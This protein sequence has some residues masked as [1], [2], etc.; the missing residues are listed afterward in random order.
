MFTL[1][2]VTSRSSSKLLKRIRRGIAHRIPAFEHI[3]FSFLTIGVANDKLSAIVLVVV[4]Y[5]S[6]LGV[7]DVFVALSVCI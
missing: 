1:L 5:D 3:S 2:S 7:I 6:E 4:V